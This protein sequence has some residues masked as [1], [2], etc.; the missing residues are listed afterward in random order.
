MNSIT[1]F[2]KKPISLSAI[3]NAKRSLW[4]TLGM[5]MVPAML[6]TSAL[7]AVPS[8]VQ[9]EED[10]L[11]QNFQ[12]VEIAKVI[13]AV[14]KI[15]GKNFVIDPRVK[16]RVTLITNEGMDPKDLYETLLAVL[17]VHGYVAVASENV[18]KIIPA[19]MAKDKIPYRKW[20]ETDEDWATE[21]IN[22]EHVEATKLV[23]ILR[24]MVA[25]EGHLV[26]LGESNKLILTDTIANIQRIK[27][28]L[29]RVDVD[30][31]A[32]YE[33]IQVK[34]AP[35]A[36]LS[37]TIKN[38][39]PKKSSSNALKLSVDERTN[40]IILMGD[41]SQRMQIRALIADL[42]IA[43][44][45][46]GMLEVIYLRYA[47]A[48]EILPVLQK[49]AENTALLSTQTDQPNDVDTTPTEASPEPEMTMGGDPVQKV[50]QPKTKNATPPARS[51]LDQKTLKNQIRIEADER[52]N[53]L[54]ISAPTAVLKNL[55][56]VIKQLDIRRAQVL[57]EAVFV[58]IAEDRSNNLGVEW[59]VLG[60]S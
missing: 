38:L 55:K 45:A 44:N 59:S 57:I 1:P 41:E 24:P 28:V 56:E 43:V 58:E 47:K 9:A 33:V 60:S 27:A 20:R 46:N 2:A 12:N 10:S 13:E 7:M 5:A 8:S 19:N 15:S 37:K 53:A 39:L 18:I 54:V 52:M 26:A 32:G 31:A 42:D 36:D 14:A 34:H 29:K 50:A 6:A 35:A 16:G 11:S 30:V 25:R 17:D 51:E 49:I 40:R 22:V 3:K 23:A 48:S 21:V 4:F